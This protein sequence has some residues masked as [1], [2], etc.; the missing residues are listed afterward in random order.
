MSDLCLDAGI[1]RAFAAA[2]ALASILP[3][4]S[5][6]EIL[7]CAAH[8]AICACNHW[9]SGAL[10][11][12]PEGSVFCWVARF[13]H[14]VF[15][16]L[17]FNCCKKASLEFCRPMIGSSTSVMCISCVLGFACPCSVASVSQ[18]MWARQCVPALP[19]RVSCRHFFLPEV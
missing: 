8:Q 10:V 18:T 2:F 14:N 3:S 1:T 6:I 16:R 4:R 7:S 11:A 13:H 15:V 5:R 17:T 19:S 12:P 9:F